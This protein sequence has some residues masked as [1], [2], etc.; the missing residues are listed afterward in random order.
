[1]V[2]IV[3]VLRHAKKIS[4]KSGYIGVENTEEE[5]LHIIGLDPTITL[6]Y[7]MKVD[8]IILKG[9]IKKISGKLEIATEIS[10][11]IKKGATLEIRNEIWQRII[12]EYYDGKLMLKRN[13]DVEPNEHSSALK[14]AMKKIKC[15]LP[16]PTEIIVDTKMLKKVLKF[17]NRKWQIKIKKD[18]GINIVFYKSTGMDWERGTTIGEV[19]ELK[20][21]TRDKISQDIAIEYRH[22]KKIAPLLSNHLYLATKPNFPTYIG[23]ETGIEFLI[24]P[25]IQIL[26]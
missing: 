10:P 8:N 7:N 1:M 2:D 18:G 15:Q 9:R 13:I 24:A 14:S 12:A 23:T 22:L 5:G 11:T 6:F 4:K 3:D 25:I 17:I 19:I 20:C 26:G 21:Q 16:N